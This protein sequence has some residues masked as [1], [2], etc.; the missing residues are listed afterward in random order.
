MHDFSPGSLQMMTSLPLFNSG[1]YLS[2]TAWNLT[3]VQL[4]TMQEGDLDM[5]AGK[6]LS[7]DMSKW[8]RNSFGRDLLH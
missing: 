7:C 2:Y 3:S 6:D 4:R 5:V 1:Y 8:A